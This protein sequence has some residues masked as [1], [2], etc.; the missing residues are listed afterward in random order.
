MAAGEGSLAAGDEGRGGPVAAREEGRGRGHT[1][2]RRRSREEEEAYKKK[3]VPSVEKS[4]RARGTGRSVPPVRRCQ[5]FP[6]LKS[7]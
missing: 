2:R 1:S 7:I 6:F 4:E 3:N 5:M